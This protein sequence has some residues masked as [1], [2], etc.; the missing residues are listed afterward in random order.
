MRK[1]LGH[2]LSLPH[3][4]RWKTVSRA[5]QK[6]TTKPPANLIENVYGRLLRPASWSKNLLCLRRSRRKRAKFL[7][8]PRD[9][10]NH[11]KE[12]EINPSEM[13]CIGFA[14]RL[15][16]K[17][18]LVKHERQELDRILGRIPLDGEARLYA[19]GNQSLKRPTTH[20]NRIGKL[21]DRVRWI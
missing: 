3:V 20:A 13:R 10:A 8:N 5:H 17:G 7:L 9:I 18:E 12:S 15:T 16:E 2:E 21:S 6:S 14:Q 19:L 4:R 11:M 1:T